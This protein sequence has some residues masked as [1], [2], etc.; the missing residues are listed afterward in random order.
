MTRHRSSPR[1]SP[2]ALLAAIAAAA[3]SLGGCGF[4]ADITT[5]RFELTPVRYSI[6]TR[7]LHVPPGFWRLRCESDGSVCCQFVDCAVVPLVCRENACVNDFHFEA[8]G[9]ID[10]RVQ[11]PALTRVGAASVADLYLSRIRYD[12]DNGLNVD[13][14]AFDLYMAPVASIASAD[15]LAQKFAVIPPIRALTKQAGREV[16]ILPGARELFGQY[17][18]EWAAFNLIVVAP[19]VVRSTMTPLTGVASIEVVM[20]ISGSLEL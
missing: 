17:A 12:M 4:D 18:K 1:S 13:L 3:A 9:T 11:A 5:L 19:L 10:L 8:Y 14:P 7:L 6:D 20:E 15:P 16:Q 2:R